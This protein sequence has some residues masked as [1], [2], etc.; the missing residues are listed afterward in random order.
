VKPTDTLSSIAARHH[1][2]GGWAKIY[3]VNSSVI[4]SNPSLILPGMKL[5]I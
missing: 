3:K 1:V 4:G 2:K 5:K